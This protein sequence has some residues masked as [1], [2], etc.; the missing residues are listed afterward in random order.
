M[1]PPIVVAY[2]MGVDSTAM[3]IG[4]CHR[5]IKPDLI[6]FAD[7]GSEKPETY[8]YLPVIQQWLAKVG[9]PPVTV[10]KYRPKPA[11]YTT[12]E[13]NCLINKT[14]PSLAFGRK[15]CSLKWKRQ[16]QDRYCNNWQPAKDCWDSGLKV[17]KAIG[18]D[19]SPRDSRRAHH[20]GDD[21]KYTYVYYL[22]E[23]G[24]DREECKRVITA[25]GLP[26]PMKSACWFC[27]A[28]QPEE[29]EWLIA[30]HPDLAQRIVTMENNAT[31]NLKV[32]EGL[33]RKST[34]KRP[35]SMAM[36]ISGKL[37]LRVVEAA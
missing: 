25:E 7:T 33:L 29:I 26:L 16:P 37:H 34:K 12:L 11:K 23:W 20:I 9:F 4:M 28:S 24:W 6:L 32:I 10:V 22:R 18:Y 30:H 27:P 5:E 13:E 2:G 35:G 19:T 36:F 8:A 3:L 14:L 21:A 15:A 31:N 17:I 1:N